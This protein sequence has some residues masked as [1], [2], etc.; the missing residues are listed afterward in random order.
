[1]SSLKK[2]KNKVREDIFRGFFCMLTL[3]TKSVPSIDLKNR[4]Q[5]WE[6]LNMMM[7]TRD[8]CEISISDVI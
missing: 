5:K 7:T 8:R 4:Q 3:Y 1:M 2:K 6:S